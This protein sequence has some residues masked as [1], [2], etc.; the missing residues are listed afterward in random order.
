MIPMKRLD[1]YLENAKTVA[2]VGHVNPDGDCLGSV[3]GTYRYLVE[4]H[5]DLCVTPYASFV[6]EYLKFLA[7]DVPFDDTDG[8][9]RTYDLAI[10]V[11]ASAKERIG[12]GK[13]AFE[14]A[15]RTLVIDHHETNP[16]FGDENYVVPKAASAS[17]VLVSLMDPDKISRSAAEKLYTGI[18]QD[19]GVFRYSSTSK[20]TLLSAAMLIDKGVNFSKIIEESV[21][22]QPYREMKL[23]GEVLMNS[24]LCPE[25]KFV[26]GTAPIS[27]QKKY[28]LSSSELANVV[29]EL[30]A[31]KEADVALFMYQYEDGTWK[32]SLRAKCDVNVAVIAK[33]FG[34][35]GHLRASG[36]SFER[37]PEAVAGKVRDLIRT[38]KNK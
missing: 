29:V 19:S 5:P 8:E 28:G 24:V 14:N 33:E 6:P 4:N 17:E 7:K 13:A 30:N 3:F 26:Y 18:M 35:G 10:S 22:N 34:G 23:M 9:D 36:F 32:A 37:D 15:R 21:I 27:L 2:I 31:V 20:E 25:T 1:D 12:A 16:L 38:L 11:D